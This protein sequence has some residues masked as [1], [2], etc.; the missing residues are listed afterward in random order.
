MDAIRQ[1]ALQVCICCA[2]AGVLQM[3][4]PAK[5]SARVIKTVLAMYILVSLLT[6]AERADWS[7]VRRQ[8]EAPL[9]VQ[10]ADAESGA[11][12]LI[13]ETALRALSS[14]LTA[15]LAR[16]GIEAEVT[17][18][19]GSATSDAALQVTADLRDHTQAERAYAILY[20]EMNGAGNILCRRT[21]EAP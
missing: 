2:L 13:E 10:A 17:V 6:P 4:L 7:E 5:G 18:D 9:Q 14:R 8:L 21:E 12:R 3:L 15:Q 1:W 19:A 20:K 16:E 11:D